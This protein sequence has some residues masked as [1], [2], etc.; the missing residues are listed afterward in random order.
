MPST[1]IKTYK[2]LPEI[3]RLLITFISGITYQYFDVSQ[4]EFD[5]FKTSFSKGIHF[6]Q[7]IKPFH[8]FEKLLDK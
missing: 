5:E 4:K 7:Q 2:Y 3:Q 1:V 8:K 6:N